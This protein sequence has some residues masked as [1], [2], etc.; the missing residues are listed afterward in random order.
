MIK[1]LFI[2]YPEN[3]RIMGAMA[4]LTEIDNDTALIQAMKTCGENLQQAL[5]EENLR[6]IQNF[7]NSHDQVAL[8]VRGMPMDAVI[9]PVERVAAE[10]NALLNF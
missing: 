10:L 2:S 9:P 6:A 8:L 7:K 5:S 4:Y 1:E 3:H